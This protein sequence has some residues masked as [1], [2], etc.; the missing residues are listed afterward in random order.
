[1]RPAF[2]AGSSLMR[3]YTNPMLWGA[4]RRPRCFIIRGVSEPFSRK[5]GDEKAKSTPSNCGEA[6]QARS[7]GPAAAN[8]APATCSRSRPTGRSLGSGT[9]SRPKSTVPPTAGAPTKSRAVGSPAAASPG[10]KP[11]A[12][13][14]KARGS[15]SRAG[16]HGGRG[17][18]PSGDVSFCASS[19]A[20]SAILSCSRRD[21]RWN[22]ARCSSWG[23]CNVIQADPAAPS[24]GKEAL[25]RPGARAAAGR[26]MRRPEW[27]RRSGALSSASARTAT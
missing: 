24:L 17:L 18:R 23:W 27:H 10:L 13:E 7:V 5:R 21:W 22:W 4:E 1:M 3:G 26:S 16:A 11:G 8:A 19:M 12:Y 9:G 20:R 14:G 2:S 6:D 25:G 15:S